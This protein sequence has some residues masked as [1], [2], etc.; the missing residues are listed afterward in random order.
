MADLKTWSGV[1]FILMTQRETLTKA[2]GSIPCAVFW[3]LYVTIT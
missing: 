1:D 3:C 2:L